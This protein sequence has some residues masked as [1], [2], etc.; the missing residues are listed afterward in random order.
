MAA[1][2]AAESQQRTQR[3]NLSDIPEL[4]PGA[5]PSAN[6]AQR[7]IFEKQCQYLHRVE[8]E[9]RKHQAAFSRAAAGVGVTVGELEEMFPALDPTLVRTLR[10]EAPSA[11]HAI[12]TLLALSASTAEPVAGSAAGEKT[13]PP[14]PAK[15]WKVG[16]EDHS[17]FPSLIDADGWQVPC[18]RTQA[19]DKDLGSAW[20]DRAK[21]AA[22][23]PSP[24]P[25]PPKQPLSAWGQ[26]RRRQGQKMEE[27]IEPM[28]A[29]TEYESRKRAG[30]Q[31]LQ[32]RVQYGRGG[33]RGA[34]AGR[35]HGARGGA[36]GGGDSESEE[37]GVGE[38]IS[39][40]AGEP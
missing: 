36:P 7:E 6:A 38:E 10:A 8:D 35:G 19:L 4:M 3:V 5:N 28:P 12:E 18:A 30:Q 15:L 21:A 33:G 13:A 20:R 26:G 39:A 24:K 37:E 32:H 1:A 11:Q 29:L 27:E 17:K 14:T 23:K 2:G 22:D 40:W 31:R 25:A 9:E 34:A 16:V